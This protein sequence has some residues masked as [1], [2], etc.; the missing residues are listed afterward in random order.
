M[1]AAMHDDCP[2]IQIWCGTHQLNLVMEHIMNDVVKEHFFT[3]MTGFITHI[4]REQKLITDMNTTCP[5]IVNQWL[6]TK[7]VTKWFKIHLPELLT[8]IKS[9]Q[10]T[11]APL[12]LWWVYLLV[13]QHF[14]NN[15]YIAFS[16][17]EG[18]MTLL[19]QQQATL[20]NLV[21]SFIDNVGMIS[22]FTIESI[23]NLDTSTHVIN[24]LYVI[25]ISSV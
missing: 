19:E 12:H 11:S 15:I 9:K 6:S 18:L 16:S 22:P 3:I 17:I 5:R 2:L 7:K 20:N 24:R 13:M 23:G 21:A 10:P 4:I 14:M 8:H 25:S 1:D